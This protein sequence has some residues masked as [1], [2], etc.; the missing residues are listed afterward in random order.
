MTFLTRRFLALIL[1][2]ASPALKAD[3]NVAAPNEAG[4]AA[5][6]I[7]SA[8]PLQSEVDGYLRLAGEA[9]GRGNLEVA[10]TFYQ[11]LLSLEGPKAVKES[12]LLQMADLYEK[13]HEVAKA[14]TVLEAICELPPDDQQMP[15]FLLRLGDLY[16][17]SGVYQTA[18]SR[19]Y[20]VLNSTLKSSQRGLA[21]SKD[22]TQQAQFRIAETYFATGDYSQANKL[23]TQVS[24]LDLSKEDKARALFRSTYC[25]Y[26]L[27]DKSG[28]ESSARLFLRDF[29]DTKFAPECRYLLA[30]TLQLLNRPQEAMDEVLSLLRTE[31]ATAEKDPKTWAYWQEKAG[32]QIANDFYLRGDFERAV[33]VCQTLAKLSNSPDWLWPVIYQMG[34]CF[35]RLQLPARA[36]EAYAFISDEAKKH[37]GGLTEALDQIV[38][39]AAWRTDEVGWK[40]KTEGRLQALL[41]GLDLP[42]AVQVSETP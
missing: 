3:E 7:A 2:I 33:N 40:T 10:E 19:Y 12:A 31:K 14:I 16:R 20:S 8:A 17:D 39:M 1:V 11:H 24:K 13:Q 30:R 23:F 22:W 6:K 41:G 18:V 21:R 42:D 5:P 36:L 15:E 28:A 38:K 27:D 34:L 32:N 37:P 4:T 9:V 26:L 25:L 29:A 35:E